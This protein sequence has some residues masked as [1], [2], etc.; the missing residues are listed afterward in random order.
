M[1]SI[2][3]RI[4]IPPGS[5][6][7]VL[8]KRWFDENLKDRYVVDAKYVDEAFEVYGT[9]KDNAWSNWN[10]DKDTHQALLMNPQPIQPESAS[11]VL[12]DILG[13]LKDGNTELTDDLEE[14]AKKCLERLDKER[15]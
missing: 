6:N 1:K 3:K 15:K 4:E 14:R 11:K 10:D 13:H 2:F 9:C 7:N 8:F 5:L 12:G